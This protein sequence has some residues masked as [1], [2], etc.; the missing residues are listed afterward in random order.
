MSTITKYQVV[1]V[2]GTIAMLSV[3]KF[4]DMLGANIDILRNVTHWLSMSGRSS[5]FLY[6]MISTKDVIY[7]LLAIA[8]FLSFTIIRL[9]GERSRRSKLEALTKYGAVFAVAILV[10]YISNLPACIYYYDGTDTKRNTL[11][12]NSQEV[13]NKLEGGLT[14][15]T[16]VNILGSN[17]HKGMPREYN[18]EKYQFEKYLRFKPELKMEYVYYYKKP[19]GSELTDRYPGK[20][21][22][23]LVDILCD[24]NEYD[25]DMFIPLAELQKTDDMDLEFE[26]YRYVRR[27]E[28]ESGEQAILRIYNDMRV[29]PSEKEISVAFKTMVQESPLVGFV[30]GHGERS[31]T[32][33]SDRGYALFGNDITFR[34]C[35]LNQGFKT[36]TVSLSEE[37]SESVD[38]LVIS[39]VK[40]HYSETEISN[41]QKFIARGGNLLILGEP[42]RQEFMNPLVA[43]LG[44]K[45]AEGML[46][47]P[48]KEYGAEVVVANVAN[49]A[50][51]VSK[52]FE[53]LIK[54]DIKIVTPSACVLEYTSD[55]GF[56]VS[57]VL[58]ANPG[59]V[60]NDFDNVDLLSDTPT[61]DSDESE[62]A[63]PIM[64]YLTRDVND[65]EQR[66][67]VIGD[68]DCVSVAELNKHRTGIDASNFS[69]ITECFTSM[70]YEEYPLDVSRVRPSDD[71][72][73]LTQVADK[74]IM[75]FFMY[76]LPGVLL[77]YSIYLLVSRK[78]K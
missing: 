73:K 70:S 56:D 11:S 57:E 3:L 16:Y 64:L 78:R 17:S 10:G 62:Q 23:E 40:S 1:A 31:I 12:K 9:Q 7:F 74:W 67:V 63:Y 51:D 66:I 2:I 36:K 46:V 61:L 24:L 26:Q 55:K 71:R 59:G 48:T 54:D 60:W 41:F 44:V 72:V 5:V 18:Y 53:K 47:Q 39:D 14:M 30:S 35:L 58:V 6:G 13:I 25:R 68:S 69:L 33:V 75:I 77:I 52:G 22:E 21:E 28:R 15:T 34:H 37:V 27:L 43:S 49:G 29:D 50:L 4:I 65:K 8:M 76:L 19:E 20:T 32:D 45:F 42:R 38:I